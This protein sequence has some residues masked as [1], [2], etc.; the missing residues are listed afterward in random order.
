MTHAPDPRSDAV[1]RPDAATAGSG[2]GGS[3][4]AGPTV[5]QVARRPRSL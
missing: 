3:D 2:P 4:A 5:G 1:P